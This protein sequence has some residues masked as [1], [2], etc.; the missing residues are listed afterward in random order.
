MT[1]D[2]SAPTL[3]QRMRT[4]W[5]ILRTCIEER[6]VYRADFALGTLFRFL[7][8]VTQ[9][10]LWGAIFAVGTSHAHKE[11]GGYT[12]HDMVAYYL[13]TM[14]GRAFSSMPGLASGIA[15]QV[16]DG[17]I[18]KFLTQ[19]I[20][21]LGYLF[22]HRVAHK[23]VYYG[24]AIGPF[25]LV[26]WLCRS[27]FPAVPDAVTL[28]AFIATLMM[29]FLLGFL[30]ESLLG[31]IA[32]WFLEVSSLLF[33]YMMLNY[34]LSGHMIPLDFLPP[35]I[36]SVIFFSPFQYLAYTP[37]AIWLG[38][39]T[40]AEIGRLLIVEAAWVIGLLIANRLAFHYGVKRYS[41]FGG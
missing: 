40:H 10:F 31:L 20:D 39:Y 38:K 8:I 25:A 36:Q 14:V 33:I 9:I 26:F 35:S 6:L 3:Q 15:A 29:A 22:W 17:S 32:F 34:F 24:V 4:S 1:T 37:A 16:R 12:Y 23:L 30:I 11:I 13:L 28:A 18:K 2:I 19:P 21:M 5:V 7:P 41:A 27:Y